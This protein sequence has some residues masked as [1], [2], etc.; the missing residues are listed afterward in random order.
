[1]QSFKHFFPREIFFRRYILIGKIQR[2][3]FINIK[4]LIFIIFFFN[5][6]F[7]AATMKSVR[8]NT[9]VEH[10]LAELVVTKSYLTTRA[11]PLL[12]PTGRIKI[13]CEI[14]QFDL[15]KSWSEIELVD[16]AP[17]KLAQVIGPSLSPRSTGKKK[18][19]NSK[20]GARFY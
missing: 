4:I 12:F 19:Y 8:I 6:H 14:S 16:N 7:Q 13:R 15:Y 9:V 5:Y 11:S 20:T 10:R 18:N 17:P 3:Q 2:C 1:M